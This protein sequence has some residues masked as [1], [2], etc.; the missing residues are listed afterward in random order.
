MYVFVTSAG[1][2]GGASKASAANWW[3][4]GGAGA[5]LVVVAVIVAVV[6]SG[7]RADAVETV[8]PIPER[9]SLATF[10]PDTYQLIMF[11]DVAGVGAN[12]SN[13]KTGEKDDAR[14]FYGRMVVNG[15]V[16]NDATHEIV[17]NAVDL[18]TLL[19]LVIVPRPMRNE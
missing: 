10:E 7:R 19:E 15:T 12:T 2:G 11:P 9:P 17:L 5:L 14:K 1:E 18:R 8:L 3:I 4:L 6:V 13:P 16:R